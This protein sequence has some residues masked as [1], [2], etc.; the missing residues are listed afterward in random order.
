M[1]IKSVRVRVEGQVQGVWFRAWTMEQAEERGLD[2]WVRNR[3]DGSVEAVFSGP[4]DRVD[5]M[6][7]VCWV[8]PK[9]A[10]VEAVHVADEV[11]EINNDFIKKSTV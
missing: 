8:G 11:D 5:D 1:S 10:R 4:S 6:L 2:G 9:L 7:D 3:H